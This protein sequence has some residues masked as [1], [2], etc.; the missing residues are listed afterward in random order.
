MNMIAAIKER[1]APAKPKITRS[2]ILAARPLHNPIIEWERMARSGVR[3]NDDDDDNNSDSDDKPEIV[4]LVVLRVPRRKDKWGN[5][6]AV[7]LKLPDFRKVEL[8]EMGSDVWERCDGETSVEAINRDICSKYRLNKRQGEVSVTAYL[9]MLADRRF[10]RLKT[11]KNT[12]L[13]KN[14]SNKKKR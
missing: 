12:E 8:D 7:W 4:E 11:G 2:E 10:I 6:V 3:K 14:N 1:V 5:F 13:K 9:K